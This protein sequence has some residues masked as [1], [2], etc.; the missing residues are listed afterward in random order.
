MQADSNPL[1]RSRLRWVVGLNLAYFFVEFGTAL[2]IG[3]VSLLADS[4]DFLEDAGLNGLI[5]W[6]LGWSLAR[7]ARLGRVLAV[8]LF[9]P[10]L[11]AFVRAVLQVLE[12]VP[13]APVPLGLAGAG[14][15]L[16]NLSCAFLV[17]PFR[18]AAGSLVKAAF[19]SARNDALAN[20]AIVG[21]ALLTA[22]WLTIWPDL[23]VGLFI[24]AINLGA[25][26]AVWREA[27][28]ESRSASLP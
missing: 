12:P 23:V 18:A 7:R 4:I 17:A 19:Y 3:S 10:G 27:V 25:A 13:P 5:L 15:L 11:A 6:G 2:A 16:V 22:R 8:I 24:L 21:A 14:A 28:R 26:V 1:L 20:L 9:L